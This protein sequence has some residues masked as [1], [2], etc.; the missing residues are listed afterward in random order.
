MYKSMEMIQNFFQSGRNRRNVPE[1]SRIFCSILLVVAIGACEQ[2]QVLGK[3]EPPV[4]LPAEY[5]PVESVLQRWKFG[6]ADVFHLEMVEGTLQAGAIPVVLVSD[7]NAKAAI[8]T[9]LR[10]RG[11][12]PE[13]VRFVT[14]QTDSLWVRDY[15]PFAIV[16]G[17]REA[18]RL[19][20]F[21]YSYP[22]QQADDSAPKW[23]APTMGLDL[24]PAALADQGL[25]VDGGDLLTDG[26]GASFF[27]SKFVENNGLESDELSKRLNDLLGI[28]RSI[29]LDSLPS[30]ANNHVDMVLKI[31]DEETI[32]LGEYTTPGP[33]RDALERFQKLLSTVH[34]CYGRP[35]RLFRIPMP[36]IGQEGD[37]RTYLNALIVNDHI[38][39]PAYG[40]PE[41]FAAI[42]AYKAAAPGYII[43]TLDCSGLIQ[44]RGAIHCVTKEY[45]RATGIRIA[46]ARILET[47]SAGGGIRFQARCFSASSVQSVILHVRR[48]DEAIYRR[49]RMTLDEDGIHW[50][51]LTMDRAGEWRY[52]ISAH[53]NGSSAHKPINGYS[54]GYLTLNVAE[55]PPRV[56]SN[57]PQGK[58]RDTSTSSR[59][60]RFSTERMPREPLTLPRALSELCGTQVSSYTHS[61]QVVFSRVTI[62]KSFI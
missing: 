45:P 48:P 4:R 33:A 54:G 10:E 36:G 55:D 6:E 13:Q 18:M 15:A 26:Y 61:P 53:G 29:V 35:F 40:I 46:H 34:S 23:I 59:R 16:D 44:Q 62:F 19:V 22:G 1:R 31:L 12:H 28:Q 7:K 11:V 32:L 30:G 5:E 50:K 41:D 42:H 3:P 2:A 52:R 47:V 56:S 21:G 9:Y 49:H 24:Y 17:S 57:L 20:D 58:V 37:F 8:S 60:F 39:V 27:S 14:V 38:F 25:V 51:T 43:K